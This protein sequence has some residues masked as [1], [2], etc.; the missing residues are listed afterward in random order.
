MITISDSDILPLSNME[1]VLVSAATTDTPN[2]I[3]A[4][5]MFWFD[6]F[7]S[8][9]E[10]E[11]IYSQLLFEFLRKNKEVYPTLIKKIKH[12]DVKLFVIILQMMKTELKASVTCYITHQMISEFQ[13]NFNHNKELQAALLQEA[14]KSK[15]PKFFAL[16]QLFC[17]KL[18]KNNSE[19]CENLLQLLNKNQCY[20]SYKIET[21]E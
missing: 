3:I 5:V 9:D 11:K 21:C 13:N 12:I 19:Y 8:G 14:S 16:M 18:N 2:V 7:G 4:L 6:R 17:I 1:K 20:I 10:A 15:C